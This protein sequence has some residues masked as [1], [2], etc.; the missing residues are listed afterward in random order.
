MESF[1]LN[2]FLKNTKSSS[3]YT[4]SN[5]YSGSSSIQGSRWVYMAAV[6]GI[7]AVLLVLIHFLVT[8]IFKT[9][10]G[11]KGF[12]PLPTSSE[13]VFL[14]RESPTEPG[15]ITEVSGAL[16]THTN[17][18]VAMDILVESINTAETNVYLPIFTIQATITDDIS[19]S[20]IPIDNIKA[21]L[22]DFNLAVYLEKGKNDLFVSILSGSAQHI[23]TVRIKNIPLREAFRLVIVVTNFN[24]DVYMNGYLSGSVVYS[25]DPIT[26]QKYIY[27]PSL[28]SNV[29]VKNVRAF[30]RELKPAEVKDLRIGI[31]KFEIDPYAANSTTC[32]ANV[33]GNDII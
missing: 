13:G 20:T 22:Q 21:Q 28:T 29:K 18:S 8:P 9:K 5:S 32:S 3:S 1:N 33:S 31:A 24:M 27:G 12:I 26:G 23:K 17:Y 4:S 25:D 7:I 16:I 2:K 11:S 15:A 30:S 14:W 19:S 10:M 6:V